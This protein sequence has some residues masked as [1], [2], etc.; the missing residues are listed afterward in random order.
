MAK[1]IKSSDILAQEQLCSHIK[2]YAG[3]GAGKT[4]FVVEN[5]KNI[6]TKNP[7]IT[8]SRERKV[9]CITYT[10][11][12]VDEIKRRLDRFSGSTEIYTIHSFIIEHIIKPFQQDLR[13]IMFKDFGITVDPKGNISSQLEGLG[14]LH[15]VDKEEMFKFIKKITGEGIELTYS[16]YSMGKVEVN[17]DEYLN[18]GKNELRIPSKILENHVIPIKQYIWTIVRKLTHEEI[19]YFGL[20]ILQEN[21]IALYAIR[22][23]FPFIFVDEFQDTHPIQAKLIKLIGQKSSVIAVIGDIAQSIYS[24]Q[25]ARPKQFDE[26]TIGDECGITE[27]VIN[28]NRRSTK[29]IVNLCNFIRKSD[30]KVVQRSIKLYDNEKDKQLA[31]IKKIHIIC[32]ENEEA[33]KLLGS[34]I[35]EGGVVLTRSWAAAFSYIQGITSYQLSCLKQIYN[36]YYNSPIDIRREITEYNNVTWVKAFKFIFK[37]WNSYESGSIIGILEA[38]WLF[39]NLDKR[40]IT[41]K[42]IS[43]IKKLLES[44][45]KDI[46]DNTITVNVLTIFN[47]KLTDKEFINFN[48]DVFGGEFN[49]PIFAEED[50]DEIKN[51]VSLLNWY[52]S[53]KLF[54]EVFSDNSQYMTIHQAKGLEWDKVIVSAEPSLRNDKTTLLNMFSNPQLL[55]ETPA[56]EFTRMYYVACSRAKEDLYIHLKNSP[57]IEVLKKSLEAYNLTNVKDGIEYEIMR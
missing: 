35:N 6:I 13:E 41:P 56:E 52:T 37:L 46:D 48:I 27:Y 54:T 24:F 47:S 1:E 16:K 10:N 7:L 57:D 51:N 49:V 18:S 28:G 3:P 15:G 42:I 8:Q 50:R 34:I 23:K 31:E 20:R 53:Y 44:V 22:V 17:N 11:A 9:L 26:F 33:Y 38:I 43:Q 45:F 55:N 14:I 29:N 21:R 4:H 25:G 5:V 40:K 32:G 19:L 2:I 36:A 30:I 12:A 39:S